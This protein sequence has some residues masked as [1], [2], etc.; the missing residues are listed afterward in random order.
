[1]PASLPLHYLLPLV[2]VSDEA[3]QT[4]KT[5][6]TEDLCETHNAKCTSGTVHV[7]WLVS[8]FE[9]DDEKDVVDRDG[10]DEIHQE[11]SAEVMN[12]DLF[13]VQDDVAVLSQN[14]RTEVE[15]QIHEEECVWQD[16]EGDPGHGVLV[17]EEGDTPGQ[18]DKIAHHQQEHYDVPVKPGEKRMSAELGLGSQPL[19]KLQMDLF[20]LWPFPD[21]QMIY[22]FT[23]NTSAH[24][25][26]NCK[27]T[28]WQ[29][30][31]SNILQV[32]F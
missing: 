14:A 27:K 1:M 22:R 2:D 10:G 6:Q 11:P 31:Y 20:V 21:L 23:A 15:N 3:R 16:V 17:F 4:E 5:Q 25:G 9:I 32:I 29:G 8:G 13:G 19:H 24:S 28:K 7:W 30:G 18:N 12:A 26:P